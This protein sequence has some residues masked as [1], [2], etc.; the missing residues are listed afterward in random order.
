MHTTQR[1]D[2]NFSLHEVAEQSLET[3]EALKTRSLVKKKT[4]LREEEVVMADFV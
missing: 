2:N 1:A 3:I 4:T